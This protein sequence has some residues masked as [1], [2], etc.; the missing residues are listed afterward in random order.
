VP[1]FSALTWRI[2]GFNALALLILIGGV[3]LVQSSGRGL[4]EERLGGVQQQ[5][6]IVAGTLAAYATD[7]E[8][9]TLKTVEAEPLLLQLIAPTRL[10]TAGV[11]DLAAT[12]G[13]K[14]KMVDHSGAVAK[15]NA[16]Y[17]N[18]Y[19]TSVIKAGTYPG[20][21]KDNQAS[22]VWNILVTNDK[23]S[24][25]DAY[26]IVKLIRSRSRPSSQAAQGSPRGLLP[27]AARLLPRP[28][29]LP[30][31]GGGPKPD[32]R[33]GPRGPARRQGRREAASRPELLAERLSAT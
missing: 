7:D 4:V 3:I 20:Q 10:P 8:T 17:N 13:V 15:M 27:D 23:M 24:D 29:R 6:A 12:P 1:H 5:A 21:D 26:D 11:T 22:A 18:L 28:Q 9:K 30:E 2:L 19:A 33:D 14:I 31:R 32:R 16:K 25:K